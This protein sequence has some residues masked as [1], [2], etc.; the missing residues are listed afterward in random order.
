MLSKKCLIE[1]S[2]VKTYKKVTFNM[3]PGDFRKVY[4]YER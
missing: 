3:L 4:F 2:K 1:L